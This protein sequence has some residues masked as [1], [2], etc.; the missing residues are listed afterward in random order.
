MRN[1]LCR[2]RISQSSVLRIV[3]PAACP[4]LPPALASF[5]KAVS[6]DAAFSLS[7]PY[8]T[9]TYRIAMRLCASGRT[10]LHKASEYHVRAEECRAL[11]ARAPKPEHKRMLEDMAETWERLAQQREALIA[12]R[13]ASKPLRERS[14]K[15]PANKAR[16]ADSVELTQPAGRGLFFDVRFFRTGNVMAREH[17]CRPLRLTAA[18]RWQ[19]AQA[20]RSAR[21]DTQ[22]TGSASHRSGSCRASDRPS[23][24]TSAYRTSGTSVVPRS[25]RWSGPQ[26]RT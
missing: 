17:R 26:S 18:R 2:E 25:G 24:A 14:T 4:P 20:P 3:T 1:Y 6:R 15:R 22:C 11:A 8:F 19:L 9:G 16:I 13:P 5:E 10:G 12:R 21:R 7:P 23:R